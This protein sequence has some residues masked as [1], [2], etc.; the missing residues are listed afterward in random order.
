MRA[1]LPIKRVDWLVGSTVFASVALVWVLLVGFDAL[2]ILMRQINDIGKG[3]Y[4]LAAAVMSVAWT[5]PRRMV[6]MFVWAVAIGGVL[7]L[8]SLAPTA[9]LVA[10]RAGGLSKARI[11]AAAAVGIA[12]L[13]AG[14]FAL[15]ETLA[16]YGES[17]AMSIQ[18]GAKSRQQIAAHKTGI[19]AREGQSLISAKRGQVGKRG[20][21][22]FD[23]KIFDFSD[24]GNLKQLVLAKTAVHEAG[25]WTLGG[26]THYRFTEADVKPV[27]EEQAA[28]AS[29]LDPRWLAQS[30]VKPEYLPLR[31]LSASI[32]YMTRNHV[33]AE[34]F[35]SAYWARWFYPLE[36][37]ALAF[38]AL[39]FAF[40]ALRSG[41]FGKRLFL[42]MLVAVGWFVL[43]K[44]TVNVA[45]VY[46]LDFRLAHLLPLAVLGASA[47]AYFRRAS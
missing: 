1:L 6:E 46:G 40:G 44:A 39:P 7:G 18:A 5:V 8:G 23:L 24:D 10:L 17:R 43:Q 42:G 9:E 33:D 38:A 26:V 27:Y 45:E 2:Q 29:E 32:D 31:D 41:G 21:E 12:I 3:G 20:I 22:L 4:T 47:Y 11:C 36:T 34:K 13:L 15:G 28:W 37:L 30:I 19:W 16:P 25:R 14:V 35:Q